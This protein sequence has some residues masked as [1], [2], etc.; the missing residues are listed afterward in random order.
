MKQHSITG[1]DTLTG[2]ALHIDIENGR[3]VSISPVTISPGPAE[4]TAWLSAGLIDL[5]VNGFGGCDLNADAL[6]ADTVISLVELLAAAGV[7][8]FLPTLITAPE[9]R[10]VRALRVIAQTRDASPRVAHAIP[11]VHIEGPFLSP[12]DGARGAHPQ[13]HIRPPSLVEFERWQAACGGLV[14]MVTLSPHWDNTREFIASLVARGI[15]VSI[16]HTHATTRQL[17]DAA[18]AGAS[19]STHLGNG[20]AAMLPRHPNPIWTQLADDRLTATFIADGHHL[21]ADTL[22]AMLRAKTIA[23]SI[24]VS[25]AT[26][27]AGMPPGAY[28]AAIG[29]D[30]VLQADGSLRMA[31]SG[32]LAGA[33]LP[34]KDGIANCASSGICTLAEAVRMATENPGRLMGGRGVLRPGTVA[35]VIRFTLDSEEK[36][37]KIETVLVEGIEQQC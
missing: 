12:E 5:Q 35:D 30:V 3:I 18:V 23:R 29:G 8:T 10:I 26:A 24:L 36:R 31:K 15:L 37:M 14:G 17:H 11:F 22:K 4:E 28:C 6:D 33:A 9:E 34:L 21:P 2:Q 20:I 27:L 13:E 25:D 7:T 32:L 1:R 19:L 16:G